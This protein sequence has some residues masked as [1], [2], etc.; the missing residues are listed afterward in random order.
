[1]PIQAHRP[2]IIDFCSSTWVSALQDPVEA[3]CPKAREEEQDPETEGQKE[4]PESKFSKGLDEH[5]SRMN[6]VVR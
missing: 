4:R 3:E 1:M 5:E 6:R 2:E